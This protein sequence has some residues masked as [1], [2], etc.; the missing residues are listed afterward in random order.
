M[1]LEDFV[2][3]YGKLNSENDWVKLAALIPWDEIEERYATGFVA[4]GHPAHS[5]RVALGALIIKQRLKCSDEW[6]VQHVSENPY[7]QYFLGQKEY[8][9]TCPFGAS[10][11]VAFRKRFSDADI[12]AILELTIPKPELPADDDED[13]PNGGTLVMDATCCPA[14][15]AYPQDINLLN[16]AREKLEEAIDEICQREGLAKPRM[17]RQCARKAYLKFSKSKKRTA[18]QTRKAIKGQLNY[19]RRDMGYI[20]GFVQAGVR[21]T[22]KQKE[23]LNLLT[24]VYEQQR[25][26]F[27]TTSHSIPRRIVSLSQPHVRPIPRGKARGKTE[28]GAKL[29]ISMVDGYARMERLSFEA[30]NE[31]DDF[32]S[33]VEAYRRRYGRYPAR[34][35]ADRIYRNRDTL[36]FCKEKGIRLT[37]PALGRPPKD[38]TVTKEARR[39]EYEDICDRNIVEGGFGT[40]KTAY[41]LSRVAVRLETTARCVIGV[42]L[43]V[44]NLMKRLRSFYARFAYSIYRALSWLF[45]RFSVV[46]E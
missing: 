43:L 16:E 7:L 30:Y 29:H 11:M 6:V 38:K 35:L 18:K 32:H 31:C 42:A 10:T 46:A 33:V 2:F 5:A 9:D 12:S 21:L 24:T 39:Q 45:F 13:P 41:G 44:M 19:I 40:V 28:F 36:A 23:L 34:I 17:Y 25:I 3:S 15:I 26:M 8:S 20:V 27:E 14:D 37:G 22:D 1:R 4:N